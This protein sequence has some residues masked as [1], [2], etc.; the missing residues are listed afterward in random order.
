MKLRIE[1]GFQM[2]YEEKCRGIMIKKQESIS[3]FLIEGY[4]NLN[5]ILENFEQRK[6]TIEFNENTEFSF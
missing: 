1:E 3:S 5:A 2:R 4:L 6:K